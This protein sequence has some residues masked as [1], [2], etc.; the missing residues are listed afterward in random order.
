[1]LFHLT[2]CSKTCPKKVHEESRSWENHCYCIWYNKDCKSSI[3]KKNWSAL[4]VLVTA[5]HGESSC[6]CYC[7]YECRYKYTSLHSS[8]RNRDV[9]CI[10]HSYGPLKRSTPYIFQ[11]FQNLF[12]QQVSA[13][14]LNESFFSFHV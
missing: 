8:L 5:R 7:C 1:M 10:H 3:F 11:W 6:K 2:S 4:F 12:L 13:M 9:L 14:K